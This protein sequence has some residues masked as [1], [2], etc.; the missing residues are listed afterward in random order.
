MVWQIP[1]IRV[2]RPA[3]AEVAVD[4]ELVEHI[5]L[6]LVLDVPAPKVLR[7]HL[8]KVTAGA[9]PVNLQHRLLCFQGVV[10]EAGVQVVTEIPAVQ[11]AEELELR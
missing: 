10:A 1:P 9:T 4:R 6:P 3:V 7:E 11:V 5:F 8:V 2:A